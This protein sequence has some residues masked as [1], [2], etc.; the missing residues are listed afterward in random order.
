MNLC[1][2]VFVLIRV[3][4]ERE[5]LYLGE[6]ALFS[7]FVKRM[8]NSVLYKVGDHAGHTHGEE[9]ALE[10]VT[11]FQFGLFAAGHA[12][13]VVAKV[14]HTTNPPGVPAQRHAVAD[15]QVVAL[16]AFAEHHIRRLIA[17]V[18]VKPLE[19][20]EIAVSNRAREDVEGVVA[21]LHREVAVT[22]KPFQ[23]V[24]TEVLA[25]VLENEGLQEREVGGAAHRLAHRLADPVFQ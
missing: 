6:S 12:V 25:G 17:M 3:R 4:N 24:E 10:G 9:R 19:I 14:F 23:C 5:Q 22:P 20:V 2:S 8:G 13:G 15:L 11:G 18:I 7:D 21:R 16:H 1:I